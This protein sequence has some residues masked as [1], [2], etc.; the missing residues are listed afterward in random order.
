MSSTAASLL[1]QLDGGPRPGQVSA[2][3]APPG[4]GKTPVAVHLALHHLLAGG[5]VLHVALGDSVDHVRRHYTQLAKS[6][7]DRV[8]SAAAERNRMIHAYVSGSF[9]EQHLR[10]SINM[11]VDIA[12]FSPDLLLFDGF[13]ADEFQNRLPLLA[14]LARSTGGRPVTVWAAVREESGG[15]NSKNHQWALAPCLV[16]LAGSESLRVIAERKEGSI[17]L[18]MTIDPATF[19][20]SGH[21]T[22][23]P[24]AAPV[25]A[26]KCT[27]YSGGANGTEVEFGELAEQ[28]GIAEVNYTFDGHPQSRISGSLLLSASELEAGDVSLTY[29]SRR[30]NRDF[31]Q[32]SLIRKV[33]Q[34]L[35]HVV[36]RAEQVFV[37]GRIRED[38]TVVGGTGWSVELGR[39]WSKDVWVYDQDKCH[40]FTWKDEEWVPGEARIVARSFAGTGTRYLTDDGRQAL[41]SLF[42]RSFGAPKA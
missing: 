13:S 15:F 28:F 33:L 10:Q 20:A 29:V 42:E 41:R 3:V 25:A 5:R 40:W 6:S 7:T 16:R 17:E 34:S 37:V 4:V 22:I 23:V 36:S 18:G 39:M 30:L 31:K 11:L 26:R 14:D 35:W 24:S 21:A 12:H 27:L 38:G 9:D 1:A 2:I 32:G 19:R 8:A